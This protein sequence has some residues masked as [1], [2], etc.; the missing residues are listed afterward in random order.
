MGLMRLL[1][2][3]VLLGTLSLQGMPNRTMSL[4]D[5]LQ[6]IAYHMG[7]I[8]LLLERGP[9]VTLSLQGMPSR[10]MSLLAMMTSDIMIEGHQVQLQRAWASRAG[11]FFWSR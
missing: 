2:E 10:T 6:H 7:L 1:L 5:R 8:R 4:Q 11:R 9:R 3:R